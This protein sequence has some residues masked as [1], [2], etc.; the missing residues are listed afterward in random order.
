MNLGLQ[1][2]LMIIDMDIWLAH[3]AIEQ[4]EKDLRFQRG[5]LKGLEAQRAQLLAKVHA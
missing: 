2:D 4:L 5:H 3:T 1:C